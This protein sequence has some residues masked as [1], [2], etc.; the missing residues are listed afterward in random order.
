MTFLGDPKTHADR[1][2]KAN[3]KG[4][5]DSTSQVYPCIACVA[6]LRS[7]YTGDFSH[8]DACD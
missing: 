3:K 8:S 6:N 7:V 4:R 5:V 1:V 2:K